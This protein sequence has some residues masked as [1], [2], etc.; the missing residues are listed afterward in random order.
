M[1]NQRLIPV[2]GFQQEDASL[3][4]L[5]DQLSSMNF[6]G[7]IRRVYAQKAVNS[8][9]AGD[10]IHFSASQNDEVVP[11]LVSSVELNDSEDPLYTSPVYFIYYIDRDGKDQAYTLGSVT[12]DGGYIGTELVYTSYEDPTTIDV[13]TSGWSITKYGNAVFSNVF[14]RGTVEATAG[15]ID[16]ILTI[17]ADENTAIQLGKGISI[18]G[19][20]S[21]YNGL[22]IN[23][24]NYFVTKE[25]ASTTYTISSA[26]TTTETVSSG[27]SLVTITVNSHGL[28]T[29]TTGS[30]IVKVFGFSGDLVSLNNS[31][32]LNTSDTNTI[33][34]RVPRITA[35]TKTVPVDAQLEQDGI[36][37]RKQI[38]SVVVSDIADVTK[39][40]ITF[41]TSANHNFIA[42]NSV[43]ISGLSTALDNVNGNFTIF[44]VTAN[45]FTIKDVTVTGTS[46]YTGLSGSVFKLFNSERSVFNVGSQT[47]YM[48]YDS[49]TDILEVTGKIVSS[50]GS[51]GGWSLSANEFFSGSGASRVSLNS[52]TGVI[53]VGP[54]NHGS[55]DTGFYADKDG[56]FSLSNQLIFT[57]V[58]TAG[59]A[60]LSTT[61]TFV[62]GTPTTITVAS[63]TGLG[64]GMTVTGTGIDSGTTV[65]NVVGTTVTISKNVLS[66]QTATPLSFILDDMSELS[67][68]GRIKGIIESVTPITSPRLSATITNATITGTS[69][70]QT[71]TFTT[72]GHAF[73]PNEKIFVEGLPGTNGLSNLNDREYVLSTV[74]DSITLTVSLSGIVNKSHPVTAVEASN[75]AVGYARYTSPGHNF[76]IGDVVVVSGASVAGYNGKFMVI[77]IVSG[78]IFIVE[79]ATV[80]AATFTSGLAISG[81]TTSTNSGL[82][83]TASLRELTMGLHPA[84]GVQGGTDS[85]YHSAGTGIRLDK[86]NWW[87]TNNQFRVGSL[88]SYFGWD[89]SRF[90]IQGGGDKTLSLSVGSLN[91]DNSF[92]IYT[93][94]VGSPAYGNA[95]TPF[96]V[97]GTGKFSLGSAL[98]WDGTTLTIAGSSGGGIQ[99]GNGVDVNAS[100]QITQISGSRIRTGVIESTGYSYTSGNFSTAG[101]QLD[102]TN[103]LLRSKNFS[104][105]SSGNAFF[106]GDITGASG[107]F[108]GALSGATG[109][110]GDIT[111]GG[112]LIAN[113]STEIGNNIRGAANYSGIAINNA[114]WNNAW[115]RRDNGSFYFKAGSE[116]GSPYIQLDTTGT[117]AIVFPNFSVDSAGTVSLTG[118]VNAS[119]GS[120][121]GYVSTSFGA[122]FGTNV[123]GANDGLWLNAN[124]YFLVNGTATLFRAG[125]GAKFLKMTSSDAD[126]RLQIDTT[127]ATY[128]VE[129]G[130]SI[131]V[132]S[133]FYGDLIGNA[134]TATAAAALGTGTAVYSSGQ[135]LRSDTSDSWA[136]STLTFTPTGASAGI[137]FDAGFSDTTGDPVITSNGAIHTY[138][139]LGRT[140]NRWFQVNTTNLFVGTTR[141]TSDAREKTSIENSDLGLDFIN[142]LRPV[143]YKMISGN[144]RQFD[145]EGNLIENLP[146]T[147]W[148]YGLIAQELKEVLDTNNLDA[149]MWAVDGFE[150]DPNGSQSISYDHIV[151]PL[152]KSVQQLSETIEI[153]ENRLAALES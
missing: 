68:T 48:N 17:G 71:A 35:G 64:K 20:T 60:N 122:R 66:S 85:W 44:S 11:I 91:S 36:A 118:A 22:V 131:R 72:N 26:T 104:I 23:D 83:A 33:T 77:G 140:G 106:R 151:A 134:S 10:A 94:S 34:I 80:G 117:S 49:A 81:A 82:S 89:G 129:V 120:F 125:T 75:P 19:D 63:A 9:K 148:H 146:G 128:A 123:S 24:T 112:R 46:P 98:T 58:L 2:F 70:N 119:S 74:P 47:N 45:T 18:P 79:N 136:A 113:S 149:A 62:T 111:A 3:Q 6:D 59:R 32:T 7:A 105:D 73:L 103:G 67:V 8:V 143:K 90:I 135:F 141:V 4:L 14:T 121:S 28:F 78:S 41:T 95:N 96:Y 5:T 1:A 145:E 127:N 144:K 40:N 97:D 115:I 43:N 110:F 25:L 153:L 100:N 55:I 61:G 37:I 137:V 132:S 142:M 52:L 133:Y 12:T 50:S 93:T 114:S 39:T 15:K 65:T 56:K 29:N 102:L 30:K 138:G 124:N 87:L 57:P 150:T 21:I 76:V 51:I 54:G 130:G 42:N 27:L 107:T 31:W 92:S 69:P 99:P 109:S 101:T 152:I 16:G 38:T 88:G 13:G 116:S 126:T 139:R 84:E 53:A 147:R 86:F 108:S